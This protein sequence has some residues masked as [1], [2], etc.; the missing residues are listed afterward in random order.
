MTVL[1]VVNSIAAAIVVL[2]LAVAMRLGHLTAGQRFERALRRV[3][4]HRGESVAAEV[5]E[6]RA[7]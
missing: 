1:I 7:A 4:V 3:E 2:G 6:R 5:P